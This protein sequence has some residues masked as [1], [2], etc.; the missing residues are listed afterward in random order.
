M[1]EL[2]YL[3]KDMKNKNDLFWFKFLEEISRNK[4]VLEETLSDIFEHFNFNCEISLY[5]SNKRHE[6]FKCVYKNDTIIDERYWLLTKRQV[7]IDVAKK[8]Q[9]QS[10]T[11]RRK[12]DNEYIDYNYYIHPIPLEDS[13]FYLV[14]D[15][16]DSKEKA[17]YAVALEAVFLVLKTCENNE[18]LSKFSTIDATTGCYNFNQFQR[19]LTTEMAKVDR[20]PEKDKIFS[21][22]LIDIEGLDSINDEYGY[23][24]GDLVLKYVANTIKD[25]VRKTD[26]VYRIGDDE[27]AVIASYSTAEACKEYM[28]PRLLMYLNTKVKLS[29]DIIKNINVNVAIVQ[30]QKGS[31]RS[32]FVNKSFDALNLAKERKEAVVM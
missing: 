20:I 9:L 7:L 8:N 30:Y 24:C 10:V 15:K 21:L 6:H 32:D 25:K 13:I 2:T 17:K 5:K 26:D 1:K 29:E 16:F 22:I 19:A 28:L 12:E 27:F 14:L 31:L 4:F 11:V 3:V 23:E 18:L